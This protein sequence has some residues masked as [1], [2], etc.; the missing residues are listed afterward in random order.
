MDRHTPDKISV[1][2]AKQQLK[3]AAERTGP[4]A[5][6]RNNPL[7][8]IFIAFAAGALVGAEPQARKPMAGALSRVL[9]EGLV[10]AALKP[11]IFSPD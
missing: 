4:T 8:A 3:A 6:V 9:S 11:V 10:A 2:Q 7:D 5:W 1:A